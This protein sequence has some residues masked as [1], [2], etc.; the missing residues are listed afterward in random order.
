MI[1]PHVCYITSERTAKYCTEHKTMK[2]I[3]QLLLGLRLLFYTQ[4][5]SPRHRKDG[6]SPKLLIPT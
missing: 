3:Q 5:I 6:S 2:L 4:T 1:I